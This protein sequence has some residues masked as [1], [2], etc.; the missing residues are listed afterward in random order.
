M[1][2]YPNFLVSSAIVSASANVSSANPLGFIAAMQL[3]F[4]LLL[5]MAQLISSWLRKLRHAEWQAES[6]RFRKEGPQNAIQQCIGIGS[7]ML[8]AEYADFPGDAATTD[9]VIAKSRE[10]RDLERAIQCHT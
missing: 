10:N 4:T 3:S 6:R 1:F 2:K 7:I 5:A 9:E 8:K